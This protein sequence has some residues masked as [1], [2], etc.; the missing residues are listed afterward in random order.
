MSTGDDVESRLQALEESNARM[1]VSIDEIKRI[2]ER[3][4]GGWK[5]L[6]ALGALLTGLAVIINALSSLANYLRH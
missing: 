1:E 3:A 4:S 5:V 6:V 2:L